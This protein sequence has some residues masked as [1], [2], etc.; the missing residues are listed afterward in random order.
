MEV[1]MMILSLFVTT[2]FS[3]VVSVLEYPAASI[4]MLGDV[5]ALSA[6]GIYCYSVKKRSCCE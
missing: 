2:A 1:K 6:Q 4:F 5:G 3:F